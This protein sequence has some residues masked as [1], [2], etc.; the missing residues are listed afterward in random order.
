MAAMPQHQAQMHAGVATTAISGASMINASTMVPYGTA[1][2]TAF[3]QSAPATSQTSSIPASTATLVTGKPQNGSQQAGGS[4]FR[5][6]PTSS[7]AQN[8]Y[9]QVAAPPAADL[10]NAN[11]GGVSQGTGAEA[12]STTVNGCDPGAEFWVTCPWSDTIR[13]MAEH[14][15]LV[16][17]LLSHLKQHPTMK[18][19]ALKILTG[20]QSA[21]AGGNG[22]VSDSGMGTGD[23][24]LPPSPAMGANPNN[25]SLFSPQGTD[26]P[27][28]WSSG[29]EFTGPPGAS[30]S[31]T[32]HQ[33]RSHMVCIAFSLPSCF[34]TPP[35]LKN[36]IWR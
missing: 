8:L 18:S 22:D 2:A 35:R 31:A 16:Y 3:T 5:G 34:Y 21:A 28:M 13:K 7:N 24:N 32:H 25:V 26:S 14:P 11:E 29:N 27:G 9:I 12:A 17:M 1:P 33:F 20:D 10:S 23:F 6:L 19:K 15:N 36:R 4:F 30:S